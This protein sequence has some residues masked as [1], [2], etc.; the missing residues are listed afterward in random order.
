MAEI[1]TK[2]GKPPEWKPEKGNTISN[3]H[4]VQTMDAWVALEHPEDW[5]AEQVLAEV[6]KRAIDL[7]GRTH[8]WDASKKTRIKGVVLDEFDPDD[9][10]MKPFNLADQD[11]GEDP[12][13]VTV[14]EPTA[15][16]EGE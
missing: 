12:N 3:L 14:D 6:Q 10:H 13:E 5:S 7:G 9:R 4:I 11:E 15:E 8:F 1:V 16:G 2:D